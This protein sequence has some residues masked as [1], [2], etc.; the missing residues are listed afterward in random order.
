[1]EKATFANKGLY[2]G[3]GTGLILFLLV[4]MFPGSL[5]GGA[6]GL[7]ISNAVFG[8]PVE[9]TLLPRIITVLSMVAGIISSAALFIVGTSVL[10]WSIGAAI[11]TVQAANQESVTTLETAK[12]KS[13]S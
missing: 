11:D 5:I 8:T 12:E 7:L 6:A 13:R 4:G 1:M 10:G 2:A 9:P 3:T